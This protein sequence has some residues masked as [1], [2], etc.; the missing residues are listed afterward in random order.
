MYIHWGNIQ[1]LDLANCERLR[2][3]GL[4]YNLELKDIKV[5]ENSSLERFV[6]EDTPLN[7]ASLGNLQRVIKQNGGEI[8]E[9]P[10]DDSSMMYYGTIQA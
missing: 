1:H 2:T 3:L 4:D 6:Y 8:I 10:E 5:S 7:E 9:V